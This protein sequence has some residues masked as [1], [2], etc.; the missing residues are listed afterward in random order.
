[1]FCLALEFQRLNAKWDMWIRNS[2]EYSIRE[3]HEFLFDSC[4]L[5]VECDAGCVDPT[6]YFPPVQNV[7]SAICFLRMEESNYIMWVALQVLFLMQEQIYYESRNKSIECCCI[8]SK[9]KHRQVN[10]LSYIFITLGPALGFPLHSDLCIPSCL[11]Q[12]I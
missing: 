11:L 3:I 6:W 4:I 5:R 12:N 10:A 7:S 1:M 8:L 9:C 2:N